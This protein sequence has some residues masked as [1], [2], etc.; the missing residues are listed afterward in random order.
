MPKL[1]LYAL[2]WNAFFA[3]HFAPYRDQGLI[4]A[5]VTCQH[6]QFYLVCAEQGELSAEIP[7]KMRYQAQAPSELPAVGDWVAIEP[8]SGQERTMVRAVLQRQST[9]SR[10][11]AGEH[12]PGTSEQIIA[13]NIDTAFLVSGLDGNYNLRRL[14]R[15]LTLAWNSGANPVIILN[16]ADVCPELD[17]RYAEVESIAHGVP[18]HIVSATEEYGLDALSPYLGAGQTVVLTGSSGV[19]KSTLTNAL[20][21]AERLRVTSVRQDDSQGRHT[22]SHREL[23][24]LPSGGLIIDTPGMR[25]LQLWGDEDGLEESFEDIEQLIERCRFKDC[26]HEDEPGCAVRSALSRGELDVKRIQSYYKLKRELQR[27]EQR[28]Q[29]RARKPAADEKRKS[30]KKSRAS[31]KARMREEYGE[32]GRA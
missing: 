10:H 19:G 29:D 28:Q 3:E 11:R 27:L 31:G 1:D 30:R 2:G 5:R 9:F 13:A 4:A 23:I 21:G 26:R 25:E 24:F 8:V 22:T 14:E 18:I 20:L 17:L 32:S 16:K 6:R 7:G 15:Y 12:T